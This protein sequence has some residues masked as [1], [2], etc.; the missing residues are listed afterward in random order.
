MNQVQEKNVSISHRISLAGEGGS[1]GVW[2]GLAETI[3]MPV[4]IINEGLRM[5]GLNVSD[6]PALGGKQ[7]NKYVQSGLDWYY[8]TVA[9]AL[10]AQNQPIIDD[11]D[12]S[13]F[14]MTYHGGRLAGFGGVAKAGLAISTKLGAS[15]ITGGTIQFSEDA[16]QMTSQWVN[17]AFANSKSDITANTATSADANP[18]HQPKQE[19]VRLDLTKL[20]F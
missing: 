20:S 5:I 9:P 7:I 3:G 8:Q 17:E 18:T 13:I 15:M 2:A 14:T 19:Q 16:S 6:E 1:R 11:L 10:G 4:D 12:R